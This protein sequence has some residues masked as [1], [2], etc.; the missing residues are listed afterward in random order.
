MCSSQHHPWSTSLQACLPVRLGG[1]GLR[2][3]AVKLAPSA[4]LASSHATV[5]LVRDILPV[6]LFPLPSALLEEA[7]AIWS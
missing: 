5:D 4:F 2:K 7:L 6:D 1:L 3:S